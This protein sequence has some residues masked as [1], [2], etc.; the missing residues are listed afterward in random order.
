MVFYFVFENFREGSNDLRGELLR[1]WHPYPLWQKASIYN[2]DSQEAI[3]AK[4]F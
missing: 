3:D 1:G 2:V 4:L